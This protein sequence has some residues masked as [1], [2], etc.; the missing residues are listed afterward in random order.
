M[1]AR[2]IALLAVA[3]A[4]R[5]EPAALSKVTLSARAK[6]VAAQQGNH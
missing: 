2:G 1:A 4:V 5:A 3:E 6:A